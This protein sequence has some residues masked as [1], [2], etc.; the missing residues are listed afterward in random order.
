MPG[1]YWYEVGSSLHDVAES[2]PAD[3][4]IQPSVEASSRNSRRLP[5]KKKDSRSIDLVAID[6]TGFESH[7]VSQYFLRRI[8]HLT[9][10]VTTSRRRRYPKA[11][12]AIDC[13][14]HLVLSMECQR[15]PNHDHAAL[16]RLLP[17]LKA[18]FKVKSITADAGFDHEQ[19]LALIQESF[20]IRA[21]I[22][23]F[24]TRYKN[25]IPSGP[26]RRE[27]FYVFK[28]GAPPQYRQRWQVETTISM[29][30]RNLSCE[31]S[32]RSYHSQ[33]QQMMLLALT[34]NLSIV[35]WIYLF[36]GAHRWSGCARRT[37]S[38]QAV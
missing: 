36:Y 3:V 37:K 35:L 14:N 28:E 10:E 6:S 18:H 17:R 15:G 20:G 38:A 11:W 22:P 5:F 13:S 31:L 1:S 12:F 27:M 24:K 30:K 32:A 19:S 9:G 29:V 4:G 33:N 8:G 34:H 7:H 2:L 16:P 23:P 25:A 21:F 26:N